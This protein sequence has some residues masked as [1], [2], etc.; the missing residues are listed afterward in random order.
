MES[1]ETLIKVIIARGDGVSV[2]QEFVIP[3]DAPKSQFESLG[4]R[5]MFAAIGK[6]ESR[7]KEP[8]NG[9]GQGTD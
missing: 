6:W 9:T 5:M 2:K 1:D 7:R 4:K 3:S 8:Q